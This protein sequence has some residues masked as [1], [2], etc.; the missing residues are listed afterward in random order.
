LLW[1]VSM[2]EHAIRK[3]SERYNPAQT[4]E[5]CDNDYRSLTLRFGRGIHD[6]W[7]GKRRTL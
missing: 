7:S 2:H 6:R 3:K 4:W 5:K 1:C